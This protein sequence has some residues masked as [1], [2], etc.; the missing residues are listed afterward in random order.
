MNQVGRIEHNRQQ[1]TSLGLEVHHPG[2]VYNQRVLDEH[3]QGRRANL[4]PG[5]GVF[6][7]VSL[8]QQISDDRQ[9]E[10]GHNR[11]IPVPGA[12]R[13]RSKEAR[14]GAEQVLIEIKAGQK[15]FQ[16][17]ALFHKA[18]RISPFQSRRGELVFGQGRLLHHIHIDLIFAKETVVR[19]IRNHI[20]DREN[21]KRKTHNAQILPEQRHALLLRRVEQS[22]QQHQENENQHHIERGFAP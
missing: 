6:F 9:I 3:R 16:C 1:V 4:P 14:E 15:L 22:N 17:N 20:S 2:I 13:V 8:R 21:T 12:E 19:E 5:P 11:I 7:P 18:H 10:N